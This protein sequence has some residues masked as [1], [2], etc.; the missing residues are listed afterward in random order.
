MPDSLFAQVFKAVYFPRS[1]IW[2]AKRGFRPSY[3]W[4]SIMRVGD[5]KSIHIWKDDWLPG[6]APLLFRDDLVEEW[7]ISKVSGLLH[8]PQ[9]GSKQ[10]LIEMVFAP[11]TAQRILVVPVLIFP[12][13]DS[14]FWPSN[15]HGN[16]T[17]KSGY[18]F[19]QVVNQQGQSSSSRGPSL[20]PKLW[21]N[22]WKSK[23]LPRCKDLSWRAINDILPVCY[24]L[25]VRGVKV[26]VLCPFYG[27]KAETVDHVLLHWAAVQLLWF[28]SPLALR[29]DAFAAFNDLVCAVLSTTEED[30][31]AAFQTWLYAL[32]EARNASI[33]NG[34]PV[35][36]EALLQRFGRLS[37]EPPAVTVGPPRVQA[38]LAYTW[39]RPRQGTIKVNVDASFHDGG[40]T[41]FGMVTRNSRGEVLAAAASQPTYALSAVLVKAQGLRW[42]MKMAT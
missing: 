30:V 39:V 2:D 3:A 16:Y 22:F 26:D 28:A 6:G 27:M 36:I 35:S 10:D 23:A 1:G 38:L 25:R 9:G 12:I 37:E 5:G 8:Y 21:K 15:T 14:L 18:H 42:S 33:F 4:T 31:I 13:E 40:G 11:A 20:H 17:S 29:V 34:R 19:V 7:R 41:S 32:W 24:S